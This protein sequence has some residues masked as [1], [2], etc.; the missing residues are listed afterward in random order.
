[1]PIKHKN[2]HNRQKI[3]ELLKSMMI[4]FWSVI[5]SSL[6]ANIGFKGRVSK[7]TFEERLSNLNMISLLVR[8]F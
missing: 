2:E 4:K 7:I 5:D 6:L 3:G 1:M 8:Q